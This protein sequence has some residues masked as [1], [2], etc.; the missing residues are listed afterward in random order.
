MHEVARWKWNA[1]Q[2]ITAPQ[3]E[4]EL[5]QTTEVSRGVDTWLWFV[6][7]HLQAGR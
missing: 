1:G 4:R 6:E 3:R 2:P 7:G 5:L